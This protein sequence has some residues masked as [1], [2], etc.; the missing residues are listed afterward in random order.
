MSMNNIETASQQSKNYFT[1]N[2]LE[3]ILMRIESLEQR[4]SRLE[5]GRIGVIEHMTRCD[6]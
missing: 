3:A 6:S 5:L 2:D 1:L 4:V